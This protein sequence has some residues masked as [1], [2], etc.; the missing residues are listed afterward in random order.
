MGWDDR[1]LCRY[2]LPRSVRSLVVLN[3]IFSASSFGA[4]WVHPE[5]WDV[6]NEA[7]A[8]AQNRNAYADLNNEDECQNGDNPTHDESRLPFEFG[9]N[10]RNVLSTKSET[11][12]QCCRDVCI[13]RLIRNVVEIAIGIGGFIIDCGW[14]HIVANR[15]QTS[16]RFDATCRGNEVS[17]HTFDTGNRRVFR[18]FSQ[19]LL[20]R[21][22]F[23]FV[24]DLRACPVC[25]DVVDAVGIHIGIF[26]SH[27]DTGDR[28]H[29]LR[30][31]YR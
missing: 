27:F 1:V 6:L 22:S 20:D 2:R 19:R 30:G 7:Q 16:D 26:Q 24:V 25:I 4:R 14:Q 15:K 12:R 28:G 29:V 31:E 5:V 10:Q 18:V 8:D 9:K 3:S 17:H 11:V 13:P 23:H 21:S